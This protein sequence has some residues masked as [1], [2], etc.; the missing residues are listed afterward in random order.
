MKI[1]YRVFFYNI[2]KKKITKN[3]FI[4][5]FYALNHFPSFFSFIFAVQIAEI[6]GD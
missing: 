3:L 4:F 5:S 6:H 1:A 2:Y